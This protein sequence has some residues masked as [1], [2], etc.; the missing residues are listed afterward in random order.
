MTKD[1]KKNK[2][3]N[4][5]NNDDWAKRYFDKAEEYYNKGNYESAVRWYKKSI[6]KGFKKA[7]DRLIKAQDELKKEQDKW[8]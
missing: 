1:T 4:H 7:A 8:N 2:L 5:S 6:N 3:N